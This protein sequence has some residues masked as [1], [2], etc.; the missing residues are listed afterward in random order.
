MANATIMQDLTPIFADVLD[1][2]DLQLLPESN[3]STLDGWD[4]L[5]HINL[6]VAIEQNYGIH[7]TTREL[8]GLKDVGAM[9][10]LVERKT[11]I[12][13]KAAGA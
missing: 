4:S 3:A 13:E 6:V 8:E 5:A 11:K 12:N 2:P 9:A 10:D 1:Q 7:F